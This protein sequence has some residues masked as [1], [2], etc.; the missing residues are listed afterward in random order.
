MNGGMRPTLVVIHK[1]RRELETL[2]AITS[3]TLGQERNREI[4][5]CLPK[6]TAGTIRKP[7]EEGWEQTGI[8]NGIVTIENEYGVLVVC[9]IVHPGITLKEM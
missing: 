1:V 9:D 6:A 2:R 4:A 3:P 8:G 7:A 5:S